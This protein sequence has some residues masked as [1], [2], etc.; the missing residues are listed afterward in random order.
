MDPHSLGRWSYVT[1]TGKN[2]CK[3]L[4]MTIYPTCTPCIAAVG[5]KTAYTQQWHLLCQK[6][7]LH[8]DPCKRFHHNLDK[9]LEPHMAAGTEILLLG[10]FNE[11]LGESFHGLNTLT[12]MLFS[13][14]YPAIM[15]S[16]E[17]LKP[18][19]EA[20]SNSIMH[21]VPRFWQNKSYASDILCTTL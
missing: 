1:I 19:E 16:M 5:A 3:I 13:T 9:F 17:K 4:I 20:A 7:D 14:Y 15:E 6:G 8:P 21:S 11:T 12:N 10:D 2:G 18:T